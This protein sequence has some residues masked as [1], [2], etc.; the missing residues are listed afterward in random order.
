VQQR[1]A[2]TGLQS[3]PLER[4]KVDLCGEELNVVLALRLGAVH[5]DVGVFQQRLLVLRVLREHADADAGG[6][7]AFMPRDQYRLDRGRQDLAR[8][9]VHLL[10]IAHL[11]DQHDEF[12]TAQ[13]GHH[14]AGA[15]TTREARGHLHEQDVAGLVPEGVV[16]GLETIEIDEHQRELAFVA[17]RRLDLPVQQLTEMGAVRQAGQAIVRGQIVDAFLS[18]HFHGDVA[19]NASVTPQTAVLVN[20]RLTAEPRVNRGR[21]RE[22]ALHQNIAERETALEQRAVCVP[23]TL[24]VEAQFPVRLAHDQIERLSAADGFAAAPTIAK[25]RVLFPVPIRRKCGQAAKARLAL[26]QRTLGP[27]TLGDVGVDGHETAAGNRNAAD[28]EHRAVGPF[29]LEMVGLE[30]VRQ[31]DA[32]AHLLFDVARGRSRRAWR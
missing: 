12:V 10:D 6:H 8:H 27:G 16:D 32:A 2:Q 28:V 3:H 14:V 15:H 30:A 21:A 20:N 11:L 22:A 4:P 5:R 7:P 23:T 25:Q 19:R 9:G 24:D 31:F 1:L 18:L 17:A 26:A 29:A 13:A